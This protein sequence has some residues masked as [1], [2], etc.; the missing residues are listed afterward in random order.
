MFGNWPFGGRMELLEAE[1]PS[2][3]QLWELLVEGAERFSFSIHR[4][5]LAFE[6]N[7]IADRIVDLVI[8]AEALLLG[9]IDET[10]RG[11]LRFRLA[12][13]GAKFIEHTEYNERE[14]FYVMR[15]AYDARSS[16]VHGGSPK[17]TRLPGNPKADLSALTSATED[18]VRLGLRKALS[19]R[20][21]A[22]SLRQSGY[23]DTL[24]LSN[25]QRGA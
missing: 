3:L 5:N 22:N 19:M 16:I 18:L 1:L 21:D 8:A 25:A 14:V 6:R 10:Y 4:F 13:R 12:L 9:D 2:F 15:R 11:E 20:E 23:W 24:L 7:L 17:D